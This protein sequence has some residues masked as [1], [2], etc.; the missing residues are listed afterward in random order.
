MASST[1]TLIALLAFAGSLASYALA[2]APAVRRNRSMALLALSAGTALLLAAATLVIVSTGA[3]TRLRLWAT[4]HSTT[5]L[6]ELASTDI[7]FPP[8]RN[9]TAHEKPEASEPLIDSTAVRAAP[10]SDPVP[11]SQPRDEVAGGSA[12]PA[13]T[14]GA[15]GR[16]TASANAR[17]VSLQSLGPWAATNCVYAIQP[18]PAE[19][20]RWWLE[21]ECGVAVAILFAACSAIDCD[22]RES[23]SWKY[24]NAP[25][26]L[27]AK[28]YR[29]VTYAEQ[30]RYGERIR[31]VA[32]AIANASAAGLINR[33]QQPVAELDA[34]RASDECLLRVD[35]LA[36]A[37]RRSGLPIDTLLRGAPGRIHTDD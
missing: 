28:E 22:T 1:T 26:L 21:N 35:N 32:C 30:T 20:A 16:G 17:L 29:S 2:V 10:N 25:M 5:Q 7:A 18:D 13:R 14:A 27:P 4:E 36:A 6:P 33:E 19:P 8:S 37:G 15:S 24:A 34:A 9:A 12:I 11:T 31:Y 23:N 3:M